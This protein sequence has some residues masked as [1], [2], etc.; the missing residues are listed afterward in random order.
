[1]FCQWAKLIQARHINILK[2][3]KFK[4]EIMAD[5]PI[6][7]TNTTQPS[8]VVAPKQAT[9][10]SITKPPIKPFTKEETAESL[11]ILADQKKEVKPV[12]KDP[13]GQFDYTGCLT[14]TVQ[15]GETLLDIAQQYTVALQQLR[16]FN[17]IDRHTFK[18]RTG[19]VLAIPSEPVQVPY[20]A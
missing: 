1:M 4:E 14:H 6:K 17:H 8:T 20:K 5:Q 10:I 18:I 3:V 9:P 11:K 19:Q 12:L 13:T 2:F 15:A 7:P 16:Y